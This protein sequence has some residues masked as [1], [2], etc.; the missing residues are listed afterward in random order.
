MYLVEKLQGFE[1]NWGYIKKKNEIF[2]Q[3]LSSSDTIPLSSIMPSAKRF[4]L[5][6]IY[7][8][9]ERINLMASILVSGKEALQANSLRHFTAS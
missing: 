9:Q 3:A 1:K 4:G 2:T 5:A 8:A 7:D 6:S